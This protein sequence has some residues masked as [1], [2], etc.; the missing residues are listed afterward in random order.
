VKLPVQWPVPNNPIRT[1]VKM[2][3]D[4]ITKQL[5]AYIR[6]VVNTDFVKL[7]I[8]GPCVKVFRLACVCLSG[9][10]CYETDFNQDEER[11]FVCMMKQGCS[12]WTDIFWGQRSR[13]W[14]IDVGE[15]QA[16]ELL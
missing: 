1:R 8:R 2:I 16:E 9:L 14:W 6:S 5:I 3:S 10:I 13:S 11:S 4:P 12:V 7:N 15:S